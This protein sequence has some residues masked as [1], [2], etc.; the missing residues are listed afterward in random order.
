V[1]EKGR[2]HYYSER[3]SALKSFYCIIHTYCHTES[4]KHMHTH[5][6]KLLICMVY[7]V[8]QDACLGNQ[9]NS[10]LEKAKLV[11]SNCMK[12]DRLISGVWSLSKFALIF[13]TA[14][15]IITRGTDF[16]FFLLCKVLTGLSGFYGYVTK[17]TAEIP[18]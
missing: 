12:Q 6:F 7:Q 5:M 14:T 17:T 9:N 1:D 3:K 18:K 11:N 10:L 8:S 4:K 16:F 13:R 2:K 15:F